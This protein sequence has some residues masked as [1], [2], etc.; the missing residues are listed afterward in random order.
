[1]IEVDMLV[2]E[3]RD[4]ARE[5]TMLCYGEN[6]DKVSAPRVRIWCHIQ[7]YWVHCKFLLR[8]TQVRR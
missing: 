5:F 4:F 3:V 1:M 6:Y 2:E 7:S 8:D